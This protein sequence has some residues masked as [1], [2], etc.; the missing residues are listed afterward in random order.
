MKGRSLVVA[1]IVISIVIVLG[2]LAISWFIV[3]NLGYN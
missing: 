1:L 2:M 3:P